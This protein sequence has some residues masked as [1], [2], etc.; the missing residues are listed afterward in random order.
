[1]QRIALSV[2]LL[3]F[4]AHP[5]LAGETIQIESQG[6]SIG[7]LHNF[8]L[9]DGTTAQNFETRF[10]ET[11]TGGNIAGRVSS[12]ECYGSA[13]ITASTYADTML[14]VQRV[15]DTDS[16]VYRMQFNTDGW[17]WTVL[18]G[19]GKYVGATGGGHVTMGWGD[20]KFGDRLTWTSKGTV[21]LK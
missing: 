7:E 15:S 16:Y 4:A 17:D 10:V 13:E 20:S 2:C 6:V 1:M 5:A 18:S 21:T 8:D 12:G 9:G 3:A 11:G 19:T 14:C